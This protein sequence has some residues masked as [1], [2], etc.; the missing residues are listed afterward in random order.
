MSV[1]STNRFTFRTFLILFFLFSCCVQAISLFRGNS[2]DLI[3]GDGKGYYVWARSAVLDRDFNFKNDYE[4]LYQ[5]DPLPPDYYRSTPKRETSNKY[6]VGLPILE[7]PAVALG[8]LVARGI[9]GIPANGVSWIYQV[10]VS[11]ELIAIAILGLVFLRR[12]LIRMGTDPQI[13]SFLVAG[14]AIATNLLHYIAKEPT[15]A[16][17]AGIGVLC[18][19]ISVISRHDPSRPWSTTGA[20]GAGLLLGLLLL[21][22]NSNV[23][24]LPFLA[25]LVWF[26]GGVTLRLIW[27]ALGPAL[28]AV[29]HFGTLHMMWGG[30]QVSSYPGEGFT[31]GIQGIV[32]GLFNARHGLFVYHPAYLLLIGVVVFATRKRKLR[33]LAWSAL[34]SF[35]A[36]AVIN[37][38]WWCWWFGDSYGNRAYIET[39][40]MLVVVAGM[41]LSIHRVAIKPVTIAVITL[42]VLNSW[43]WLVSFQGSSRLTVLTH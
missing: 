19:L 9:H 28:A 40:P 6:P 27:S 13:A 24:L 18:F 21:I 41:L 26:R 10:L 38:N 7:L 30:L 11:L 12:A 32:S 23:A 20:I 33:I 22:R 5:Y 36:F 31:S 14:M 35:S 25:T 39:L 34:V 29:V 3:V 17:A 8:H 42:A 15:M 16:H 4:A 1:S 2:P 37:G 43:L